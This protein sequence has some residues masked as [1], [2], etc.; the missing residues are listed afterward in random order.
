MTGVFDRRKFLAASSA[1]AISAATSGTGSHLLGGELSVGSCFA[2]TDDPPLFK[3]S[4]A[5]WSL[6]RSIGEGLLDNLA[7]PRIARQ[8]FEIEAVEYVNQFFKDKARDEKYLAQVDQV[9]RDY[10]VKSLLIMIDGEGQLG[11]PV[12]TGRRKAVEN[13]FQWVDAA[14]F[15]GCHSI[16]VNAGSSGSYDE[17]AKLAADGLRQVCE[18]AAPLGISV[19]VEN[20]GGLSSNGQW[21]A[22]VI[23]TV[24][25]DN[26]GTLPD[27]GNFRISKDKMYDRYLGMAALMPFA[28]AVSAKSHDFDEQGNETHSDYEKIMQIVIDAG[29]DG[30]VGIEFEGGGNEFDGI[31]ATKRLL[32]RCR[33]QLSRG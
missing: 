32:E 19:I 3:I 12:E 11:D 14:K 29:Y 17:Q 18:Y 24:N 16:R 1:F 10:G 33:D 13:H 8:E 23:R 21:L 26:C 28:K 5:E 30:Y 15:L 7:F 6:H 25:M 27:F 20:H 4:L 2:K 9:C 22:R 31:R